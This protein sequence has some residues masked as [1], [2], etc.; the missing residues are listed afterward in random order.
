MKHD[1]LRLLVGVVVL[2]LVLVHVVSRALLNSK[3][4]SAETFGRD[5]PITL[6]ALSLILTP[7]PHPAPHSVPGHSQ[8]HLERSRQKLDSMDLQSTTGL[9]Q[10]S[11]PLLLLILDQPPQVVGQSHVACTPTLPKTVKRSKRT[12]NQDLCSQLGSCFRCQLDL[13]KAS[14]KQKSCNKTA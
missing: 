1:S 4:L 12:G 2:A 6:Y 8:A 10:D 7:G 9:L 5:V 13:Q 11:Y 14:C 3:R